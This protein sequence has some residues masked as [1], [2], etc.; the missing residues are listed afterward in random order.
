MVQK[1]M[2]FLGY[3]KNGYAFET[4]WVGMMGGYPHAHLHGSIRESDSTISGNHISYIFP[5]METAYVGRFE[6]RTMIDTKYVK[7][8]EVKC[9][10]NGLPYVSKFS[11]AEESSAN[12]YYE[13][14]SNISFGAGPVGVPDPYE[15]S[16]VDLRVSS[17]PECGEGI[18]IKKDVEKDMIV[19]FYNGFVF[20]KE[21]Q[22]IYENNCANN[23]T[24]TD[25]ERRHCFK[26][27]IKIGPTEMTINF[28][29]EI[30]N[31][32]TFFPTLGHKVCEKAF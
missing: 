9:D 29:P 21:Q 23:V 30:Y 3:Y 24:K 18:F 8:L 14:P 1:G 12:F 17:I 13:P 16:M 6:N 11:K 15:E 4:F 26:S 28:P 22:Q 27:V 19:S 25:D 32:E 31:P 20:D 10:N 5:N 7:V 2:R